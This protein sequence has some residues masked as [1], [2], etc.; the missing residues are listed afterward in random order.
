MD[1]VR[2]IQVSPTGRKAPMEPNRSRRRSRFSRRIG[3]D[4]GRRVRPR[5]Q[6]FVRESQY[7]GRRLA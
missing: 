3:D 1:V 6:G 7:S 4:P 5:R 2:A